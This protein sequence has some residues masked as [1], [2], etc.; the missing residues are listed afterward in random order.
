MTVMTRTFQDSEQCVIGM[1]DSKMD[2][3]MLEMQ[4]EMDGIIFRIFFYNSNH[5]I[6]I[7]S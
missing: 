7:K 4:C 1:E 3:N 2:V 6:V 5:F